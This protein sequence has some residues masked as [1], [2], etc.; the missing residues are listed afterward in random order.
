MRIW[1]T[2]CAR[3]LN[4]HSIYSFYVSCINF[5]LLD[6][7][8]VRENFTSVEQQLIMLSL[9]VSCIVLKWLLLLKR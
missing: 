7:N 6:L 3:Q 5:I 4:L 1:T 2:E 9:T 8:N